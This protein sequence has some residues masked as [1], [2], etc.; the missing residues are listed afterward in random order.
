MILR[1]MTALAFVLL[2]Q[3]TNQAMAQTTMVSGRVVDI[4]GAVV[5]NAVVTLSAPGAVSNTTRTGSDGSF[6]FEDV[7]FRSY[8]LQIDAAGFVRLQQTIEARESSSPLTVTLQVAG[9][10]EDV[11]VVGNTPTTL[12]RPTVTASR[13]G[14]TLIETPA[15]VQ[16]LSG[17]VIRERGDTTIAEAKSRAVGV[18]SQAS[19]GN[20]GSGLSARG[21]AGVGSVMQLYDGAQFFIGAG[22]VSFP[23][24]PWM[25]DRIEVLGGPGSVLYG[26]GAIGG[27]IN[28]VPRKP[29]RTAFDNSVRIAAGSQD[30]WRGAFGSGGPLSERVSYRADVSHNRSDGWVE[31]GESSGTALSASLRMDVTPRFNLTLQ[32]DYGYQRPDA[33]FGAPT[34]TGKVDEARKKANYN[35]ADAE[36]KYKDNWTQFKVEWL[37]S[38]NARVRSSTHYLTTNRHW[39]NA[40]NY[41]YD[42]SLAKLTQSGFLE[43]F[44]H[45]RQAGNRTDALFNGRVLGRENTASVGLEYNFIRFQHTNNSPYGGSRTITPDNPSYDTFLNIAGTSPRYR[46]H[47]HQTSIFAEDRLVLTPQVSLVGGIRVDRHGVERLDLVARTTSDRAFTPATWRGGVVY[48]ITAGLSLYGQYATATDTIGNIISQSVAQHLFDLTTGRQVEGGVKQAFW[49]ERGQWTAAVY[50]IVKNNLLAPD[51]ANP[52]TSLQIGRQSSK[53]FE[54]SASMLL[55]GSVRIDA[56][57]ALLDARFDDF[58]ENVGGVLV[59]RVGNTPPAVPQRMGNLW[60]TWDSPQAWQARAGVRYVGARFLNNVNSVR[61]SSYT[62][63][64]GGIRRRLTRRTAVDLRVYNLFDEFYAHNIYGGAAAPQWLVGRPRAAEVAFTAGF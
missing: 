52:G 28:V 64:D 16:V 42:P 61:T 56:N 63:V 41:A 22:T 11:S 20:G 15:S 25:V 26:N 60:V 27:V 7:A 36:I 10:S 4:Q 43:I 6:A 18:T 53:G 23:F 32:E 1:L 51:P 39:R 38:P 3:F 8:V 35:V 31:R 30:S 62:V 44:H 45:Q 58:A 12:T 55:P 14:M 59:S 5:V 49:N 37:L 46:T 17:E 9:I 29:S 47:S 21:F 2:A 13:L 57:L 50:G 24:D 33:Y 40:E 48:A 54:G 34:I 19:P